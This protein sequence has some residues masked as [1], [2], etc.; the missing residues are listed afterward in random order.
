MRVVCAARSR[1]RLRR[2]PA[3]CGFAP[4]RM[5]SLRY[6][7]LQSRSDNFRKSVHEA[8]RAWRESTRRRRLALTAPHRRPTRGFARHAGGSQRAK[9]LRVTTAHAR[10][11]RRVRPSRSRGWWLSAGWRCRER[12]DE[13]PKAYR[14]SRF[15]SCSRQLFEWN[16]AKRNAASSASPAPPARRQRSRS[17]AAT[18][19]PRD[20]LT[21]RLPRAP[22]HRMTRDKKKSAQRPPYRSFNSSARKSTNARTFSGK[23]RV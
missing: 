2:G 10:G 3:A 19:T 23:V 18:T 5:N 11:R 21:R 13:E 16:G 9:S 14:S 4:V 17:N 22:A 15:V 20:G 1:R 6:A 12:D 8:L 7:S